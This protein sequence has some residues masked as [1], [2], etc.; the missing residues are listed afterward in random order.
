[1]RSEATIIKLATEG[2]DAPTIAQKVGVSP[3]RVFIVCWY[4]N[5]ALRWLSPTPVEEPVRSKKTP[6]VAP[7]ALKRELKKAPAATP[8]I[9][10]QRRPKGSKKQ[11]QILE[12]A[13][14]G[15]DA[16]TIAKKLGT[17]IGYVY[18]TCKKNG[19]ALAD[20]P[21]GPQGKAVESKRVDRIGSL[22]YRWQFE[23]NDYSDREAAQ[24]LGLTISRVRGV[25]KGLV[26]LTVSECE[27]I[28][29]VLKMDF[30]EFTK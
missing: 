4:K 30:A 13:V 15:F 22:I 11:A 7:E 3:E 29:A 14:Q 6:A 18:R 26:D 24:L 27:R 17:A 23:E 20:A 2:L 21:K 1:M 16:P 12:L 8:P 19:V 9:A 5:V 10:P 25:V 28:A